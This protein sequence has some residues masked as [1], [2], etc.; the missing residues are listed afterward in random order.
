MEL[1]PTE[2]ERIKAFGQGDSLFAYGDRR[3]LMTTIATEKEL[4]AIQ[5]EY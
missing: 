4:S 3:I 2:Q 5:N 1:N